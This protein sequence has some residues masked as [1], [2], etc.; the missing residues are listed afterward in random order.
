MTIYILALKLNNL[1][2]NFNKN[3]TKKNNMMYT[4]KNRVLH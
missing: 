1:L 4:K 3:L 2:N